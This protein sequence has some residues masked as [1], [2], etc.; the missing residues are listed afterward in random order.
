VKFGTHLNQD[1]VHSREVVGFVLAKKT[2][3]IPRQLFGHSNFGLGLHSAEPLNLDV[4]LT[5]RFRKQV[6]QF[7]PGMDHDN[8]WQTTFH[9]LTFVKMPPT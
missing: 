2:I 7:P 3:F 9:M 1:E 8:K 4:H 6:H 5:K